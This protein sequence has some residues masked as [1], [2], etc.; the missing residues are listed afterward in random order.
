MSSRKLI[1]FDWAMKRLLRSKAN[2][3]ILEGFLSEL[4]R[5][6]ITILEVLESES[7][8]E[9]RAD[10]FNRV[11]LKVRNAKNE[12][13]IIEVQYER[14]FDYLQRILYGTSRV[15]TEHIEEKEPYSKVVKVISV[16]ILYFDLG[17]G[18][19]YIYHGT[20]SFQGLHTHD[21]LSLDEAQQGLYGK[22]KICE[23]FPEYYIIRINS[24]DNLAK[25]PL[26]E[27]VYFLKNEE[28]EDSFKAKGLQKAK[29]QL[30][31]LK[32]PEDERLEYNRYIDNLH[33]QASMVESSYGIGKL[34]GEKRGREQG[35]KIGEKRGREQGR[36][37]ERLH[38]AINLL[39]V[40]D[41][42]TI[43]GKT[44][45]SLEEI[46]KLRRNNEN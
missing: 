11:D 46:E 40:L 12:I 26:D 37:E 5:E 31:M 24:F 20:T 21:E 29:E 32:L 28:I 9:D 44:G 13:I 41:D 16:N 34:K 38:L 18:E 2:F 33:Y 23:L 30:D 36:E 43:A 1:S 3:E 15:I 14:E 7:N 10:K 25:D 4:T 19:D 27:W 39:D 45:L 17:Q 42:A 8:K 6:D 22:E 35:E